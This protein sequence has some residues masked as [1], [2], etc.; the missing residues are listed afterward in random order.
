MR[1]TVFAGLS[2]TGYACGWPGLGLG[3]LDSI[4]LLL[5]WRAGT[6]WP[7]SSVDMLEGVL[8]WRRRKI[9]ERRVQKD[10]NH[11][12]RHSKAGQLL[13]DKVK[14]DSKTANQLS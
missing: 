5:P 2:C 3:L 9:V 6:G 8:G 12:H 11:D 14:K 13:V 1:P 7:C 4:R 10:N